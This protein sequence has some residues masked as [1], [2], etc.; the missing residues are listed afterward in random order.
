MVSVDEVAEL[1][2]SDGVGAAILQIEP[3]HIEDPV[4]SRHWKTARTA[5][6]KIKRIVDVHIGEDDE[7]DED[8]D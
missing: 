8:Y 7:E 2:D 3:D 5:L 1:V 6:L 4:L